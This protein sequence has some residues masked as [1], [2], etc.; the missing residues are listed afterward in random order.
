MTVKHVKDT[1]RGV[2][3]VEPLPVQSLYAENAPAEFWRVLSDP[4][5][6]DGMWADAIAAATEKLPASALKAGLDFGVLLEQM[7]GEGQ[8]GEG[9]WRLSAAKR[10]Y[11]GLKPAVPRAARRVL[12]QL[13]APLAVANFPL[14]WPIEDRYAR[15]QW[16]VMRQLLVSTGKET[17]L[18][19]HFWPRELRFAF[20]LTHDIETWQ[21]QAQ[22]RRVADLEEELGFRS[23]FNFVAEGYRIDQVLMRELRERGFE[24]GIHGLKHDGKLFQSATGFIQRAKQINR[25][26]KQLESVGFRAPLTHRNPE[27][28][29]ALE[30]EYDSSF[31]DTDPYEPIPGGT[32]CIWPFV[33][34]RFVELPYTLVQDYT[35]TEILGERSARLWLEKVRFIESYCGMALLNTHP[36]YLRMDRT[37]RVYVEFLQEMRRRGDYWHTLPREV[38]RWWRARASAAGPEALAGAVLSDVRLSGDDLSI[39]PIRERLRWPM[40][41]TGSAASDGRLGL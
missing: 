31:F 21:G 11:Y 24:I 33:M 4:V 41:P 23:C 12:R 27:W 1:G 20:V 25:Y 18:F 8:F 9:H 28:M 5:L 10:L 38:A 22:V 29:Q 32:M 17:L 37:W 14:H 16:E 40:A 35:L 3:R 39:S 30:I 6:T 13:Y 26:L 2:G 15:F 34:G 19:I 7:L 36:D